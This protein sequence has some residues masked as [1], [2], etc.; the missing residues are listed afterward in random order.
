MCQNDRR[1]YGR[2]YS[3]VVSKEAGPREFREPCLAL[4]DESAKDLLDVDP[5]F[6][7]LNEELERLEVEKVVGCGRLLLMP[8][9]WSAILITQSRGPLR[10]IDSLERLH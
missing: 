10:S 7:Q 3:L 6:E 8:R 2:A 5:P 1:E 9:D 4:P